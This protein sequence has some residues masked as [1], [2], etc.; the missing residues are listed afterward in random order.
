VVPYLP[1]NELTR[2]QPARPATPTPNPP[3]AASPAGGNR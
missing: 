1:L 2:P 3:Q